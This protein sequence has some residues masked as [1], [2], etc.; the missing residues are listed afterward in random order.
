MRRLGS[1][2]NRDSSST[3]LARIIVRFLGCRPSSRDDILVEKQM[4]ELAGI[5]LS[6]AAVLALYIVERLKYGL[7]R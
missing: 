3:V 4:T 6:C 5:I 1:G 7:E 2:Y